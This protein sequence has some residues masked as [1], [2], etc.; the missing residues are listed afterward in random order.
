MC[1]MPFSLAAPNEPNV[2]TL[3][4]V[5]YSYLLLL[6]VMDAFGTMCIFVFANFFH[7]FSLRFAI[8]FT[9]KSNLSA[10]SQ[11]F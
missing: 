2:K 6:T 1:G 10:T 11:L 9:A 5:T 7:C 8:F 3:L 4:T